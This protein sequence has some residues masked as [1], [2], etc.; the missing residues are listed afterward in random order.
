MKPM[1]LV[2]LSAALLTPLVQT[3]QQTQAPAKLSPRAESFLQAAKTA[4]SLNDLRAVAGNERF[5]EADLARLEREL[6]KTGD[7]DRLERM[8]RDEMASQKAQLE[9]RS[10]AF[11]RKKEAEHEQRHDAELRRLNDR[12]LTRLR[13]VKAI[14][15]AAARAARPSG[16]STAAGTAQTQTARPTPSSRGRIRSL[17]P[18]AVTVGGSLTIMGDDFGTATGRVVVGVGRDRIEC[19]ITSWSDGQIAVRVPEEFQSVVGTAEKAGFVWV[20]LH[21]GESGPFTDATIRPDLEALTPT[22]ETLSTTELTP[23]VPLII[24][25]ANFLADQRGSVEFRFRGQTIAGTVDEWQDGYIAVTIRGGNHGLTRTEGTVIVR[26]HLDLQ[27]TKAI[28][29]TPLLRTRVL[30]HE[31]LGVAVLFGYKAEKDD[32]NMELKNGWVVKENELGCDP[33]V[34]VGLL[35]S[36]AGCELV[37]P[38]SPGATHAVSRSMIW[39]DFFGSVRSTNYLTIE[40]PAG[41]SWQ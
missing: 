1:P 20:K 39:V 6:K 17:T 35:W 40:G 15:P 22:I 37:R 27:A 2:V 25:G 19:P 28:T 11:I 13:A 23:D 3:A 18:S 9:A 29:F 38:A 34:L 32:F 31:R 14:K 5:S 10:Q 12:A 16:S 33:F 7:L 8:I 26:N 41:L 24:E 21:G 36:S 4:R 30:V